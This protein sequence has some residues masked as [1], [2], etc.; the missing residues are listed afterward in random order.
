MFNRLNQ[1]SHF[2]Q[3]TLWKLNWTSRSLD[4]TML[5]QWSHVRIIHIQTVL[6][7][8]TFGCFSSCTLSCKLSAI[9]SWH[10]HSSLLQGFKVKRHGDCVVSMFYTKISCT[11]FRSFDFLTE[12]VL[13]PGHISSFSSSC[14]QTTFDLPCTVDMRCRQSVI[15]DSRRSQIS[16]ENHWSS[17]ESVRFGS[18][19]AAGF[20]STIKLESCRVTTPASDMDL[21]AGAVMGVT[22]RNILCLLPVSCACLRR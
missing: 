8:Y 21:T 7:I 18:Q 9:L 1:S 20:S 10:I 4:N 13:I 14:Q 5:H 3:L 6:Y 12:V 11:V 22:G 17:E 19:C 15:Y 2:I 16:L